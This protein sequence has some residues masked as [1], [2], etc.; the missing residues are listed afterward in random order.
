MVLYIKQKVFT[1][2]DKYYVYNEQFQ[3]IFTVQS[4]FFTI[5]ARI[6]VYD[7]TG[8]ELYFI[9]QKLFRFLPEYHIFCGGNLCAIVKKV[10]T[11]LRPRLVIQ[12]QYGDYT[13]EGNLFAMDFAIYHEGL[14]VGEIHKKWFSFGDTYELA[15]QDPDNAAF[16]STLVIAIDNCLHNEDKN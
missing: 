10:F 3:P 4:E 11:F 6:H 12:S 9:E 2:R 15:V 14:P 1:L 7:M 8:Q 13:M 16:F 5:G